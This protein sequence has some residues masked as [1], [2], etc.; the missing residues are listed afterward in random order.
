VSTVARDAARL[1]EGNIALN[2]LIAPPVPLPKPRSHVPPA[3]RKILHFAKNCPREK[4]CLSPEIGTYAE[5]IVGFVAGGWMMRLAREGQRKNTCPRKLSARA[6]TARVAVWRRVSLSRL[7]AS[8]GASEL[9]HRVTTPLRQHGRRCPPRPGIRIR[10][11][12]R[13]STPSLRCASSVHNLLKCINCGVGS[14]L[15]DDRVLSTAYLRINCGL[16]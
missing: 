1:R 9:E 4:F 7:G 2:D 5:H 3:C 15:S 13:S 11:R 16:S 12:A 14:T 6:M 8:R 10:P